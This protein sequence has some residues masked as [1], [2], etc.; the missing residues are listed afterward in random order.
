MSLRQKI[1]NFSRYYFLDCFQNTPEI[2]YMLGL[3]YL[4]PSPVGLEP[5]PEKSREYFQKAADLGLPDAVNIMGTV[6]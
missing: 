1:V 4:N 3:F 6:E 2:L 5:N